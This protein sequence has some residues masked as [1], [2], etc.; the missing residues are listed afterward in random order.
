MGVPRGCGAA[1]AKLKARV[2]VIQRPGS[3]GEGRIFGKGQ[4]A[5]EGGE[6]TAFQEVK[7]AGME[8][9]DEAAEVESDRLA[10]TLLKQSV[11]VII[12]I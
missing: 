12:R 3:V 6:L 7:E 10:G 9:G 8:T 4:A 2:E 5:R 1:W 11:R